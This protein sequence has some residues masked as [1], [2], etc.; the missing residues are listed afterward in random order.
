[1]LMAWAASFYHL[2]GHALGHGDRCALL[3]LVLYLFRE[4]FQL[5]ELVSFPYS[6]ALTYW[7]MGHGTMALS[8]LLH[9][10]RPSAAPGGRMYLR[11]EADLLW[12]RASGL[13]CC[14][15]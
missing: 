14:V 2:A 7:H 12:F 11:A 8:K 9:R 3:D 5:E 6:R 4:A 1:M 13:S 10:S 15:V